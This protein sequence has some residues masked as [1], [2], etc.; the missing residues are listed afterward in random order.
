VSISVAPQGPAAELVDQSVYF[1]PK[2]Q[3]PQVLVRYIREQ[4]VQRMLVFTRTKHGADKLVRSL[5]QAGVRADAIHGNKTQ[6]AR[7]RA[8]ADPGGDRYCLTWF[9]Y[10]R[11]VA[12]GEL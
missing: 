7:Q 6:A 12:C 10:R 9:G 8:S 2:P 1:V 4:A 5:M 11:C 3:K